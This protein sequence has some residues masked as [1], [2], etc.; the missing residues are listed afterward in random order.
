MS[1]TNSVIQKKWMAFAGLTWFFYVIFHMVSL[2]NFHAGKDVFNGFYTEFSQSPIYYLMA[3]ALITT[4]G[5]H[6]F[7]A[8]SRQLANH[9]SKGSGYEKTYPQEIPR[10]VAWGGAGTLLVFIVF[11]FMQMQWL[12]KTDLYQ[13]ML[14]IFIQPIMWVIYALGLIT[15]SAHLHHALNNVLQT[16]GMTSKQYHLVVVL[17]VLLIF[18]G[19]SSVLVGVMYA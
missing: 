10:V 11:H 8:M 4:L 12:D 15:L 5:F 1:F 6:V 7:I 17:I 2:L 18:I 14:S 19:F 3:V 16:L 13:E 9:Q